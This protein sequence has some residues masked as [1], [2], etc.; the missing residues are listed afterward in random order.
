MAALPEAAQQ[1][2]FPPLTAENLEKKVFS[3]PGDFAGEYNLL[4]ITFESDQQRE[5]DSWLEALP[6]L[7]KGQSGISCYEISVASKEY[8]LARFVLNRAM[9]YEMKKQEQRERT[10]PVYIDKAPFDKSLG[11]SSEER[12]TIVLVDKKGNVVWRENGLYYDIKGNAFKAA[13]AKLKTAPK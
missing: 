13:L 7:L 8:K 9:R 12:S 6:D 1:G 4:L 5:A 2:V 3:L 11:I 10:F